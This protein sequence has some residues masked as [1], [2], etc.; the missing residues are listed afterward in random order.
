[1]GTCLY[2]SGGHEVA[3]NGRI[4]EDEISGVG[5]CIRNKDANK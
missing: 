2:T 1:M 3:F 4:K 5:G